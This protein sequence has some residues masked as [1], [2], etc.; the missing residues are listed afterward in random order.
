MW[1]ESGGG[2]DS[3]VGFGMSNTTNPAISQVDGLLVAAYNA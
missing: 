1:T 3:M 2:N